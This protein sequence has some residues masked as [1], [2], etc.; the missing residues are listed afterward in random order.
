MKKLIKILSLVLAVP[1]LAQDP[2]RATVRFAWTQPQVTQTGQPQADGWM[3]EYLI[4]VAAHGDTT[5]YGR[6]AAP[7]ALADSCV[8]YV[9]LEIGVPSAVQVQGVNRW[10]V[11]GLKSV[12]SDTHI[13]IPDPPAAPGKPQSQ[14]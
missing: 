10:D 1:A 7:V 6:V 5:Y 8:A 14:E 2:P 9:S 3:K 13:V 12:W 4:F 11:P